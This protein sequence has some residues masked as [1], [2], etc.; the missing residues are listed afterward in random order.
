[1][2]ALQGNSRFDVVFGTIVLHMQEY[3]ITG[4]CLLHEQGTAEG[5]AA[6]TAVYPKGTRIIL[7]GKVAS[8]VP[9]PA[10][11]GAALD[12][13]VRS[14]LPRDVTLGTLV[15]SDLRLIG[16]TLGLHD[17]VS[18]VTLVFYTQTPLELPEVQS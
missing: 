1:M 9:E 11:V 13:A 4:G 17:V 7:K 15:C 16:Y 3:Q 5:D 14:G 12:A 6:V 10:A 18:E 2:I 8:W